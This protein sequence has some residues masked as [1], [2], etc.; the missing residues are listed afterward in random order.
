M[1]G[2][3]IKAPAKIN[4][5][6]RVKGLRPD[7]YHELESIFLALDYGDILT[8]SI[9]GE[10]GDLDILTGWKTGRAQENLPQ[11]KNLIYRAVS[12]FRART[13][14]KKGLRVA[15]EKHIPLGGGLGGG[16]SDA[17]S[18]LLAMNAVSGAN[19]SHSALTEMALKLGSDVPFFLSGGAAWVSGRG[20]KITPL[21]VSGLL[22]DTSSGGL[23]VVLVNSGTPS[24]TAEAFALLDRRRAHIVPAAE[25]PSMEKVTGALGGDPRNWP[26]TNDFLPVFLEDEGVNGTYSRILSQLRETGADFSGLSGAGSTCFGIFADRELAK[27]A[28]LCLSKQWSFAQLTFPLARESK[29]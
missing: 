9:A 11:E 15:V 6:L 13:G 27:E 29:Q 1:S 19:L 26:F 5:H 12:L 23:A 4:L 28:I 2:L 21:T 24:G 3:T 7:G 18:A 16:S 8:F 20:E 10:D 22:H 14:F 17:A 25:S